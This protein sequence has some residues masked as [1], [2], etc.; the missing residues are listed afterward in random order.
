MSKNS[1]AMVAGLVLVSFI[2][3]CEPESESKK[4][5]TTPTFSEV[6]GDLVKMRNTIRDGFAANDTKKAH[7]PLHDVGYSLEKLGV[8]GAAADLT[9]EQKAALKEATDVLFE[10]FN[11]VDLTM[12]GKEGKTYDEVSAEIDAALKTIT[13]MAGVEN[14][15]AP[16]GSG[17]KEDE[18]SQESGSGVKDETPQ[19]ADP[20]EAEA[21]PESGGE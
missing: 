8:L 6:V 2:C 19:A 7:G 17:E 12:H 3:G 13:D 14:D 4:E 10:A 11:Q 20:V 9:D 1:V 15:A 5:A 21:P 18:A 16:A